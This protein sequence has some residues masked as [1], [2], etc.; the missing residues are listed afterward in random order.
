[1]KWKLAGPAAGYG[2]R[3][4]PSITIIGGSHALLV[5]PP[6][7]VSS[8]PSSV[9]DVPSSPSSPSLVSSPLSTSLELPIADVV[10][11]AGSLGLESAHDS[12]ATPSTASRN[13]SR[14]ISVRPGRRIGARRA[15]LR[16]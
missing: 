11:A 12:T 10:S 7:L 1:M 16:C 15:R 9:D 2:G 4:A 3:H 6:L 8:P 13:P 14:P 5:S